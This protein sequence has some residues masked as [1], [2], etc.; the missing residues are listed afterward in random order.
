MSVLLTTSLF[1]RQFLPKVREARMRE[2]V[3]CGQ[4]D[5]HI[6]R[7]EGYISCVRI[8]SNSSRNRPRNGVV[9]DNLISAE[10]FGLLNLFNLCYVSLEWF[11]IVSWKCVLMCTVSHT[12][13]AGIR[14]FA[15]KAVKE[16]YGLFLFGITFKCG[17]SFRIK[18]SILLRVQ[19]Q[20]IQ[21]V[22]QK[23]PSL[24]WFERKEKY[25]YRLRDCKILSE[26]FSCSN[27]N[28]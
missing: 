9:W 1:Q 18:T 8:P 22:S 5:G 7:E 23:D 11:V 20:R 2:N 16:L 15:F 12:R 26:M 3:G 24:V 14:E 13:L 17:S 28:N 6:L 19:A 21:M 10:R 25:I 27:I 4:Y